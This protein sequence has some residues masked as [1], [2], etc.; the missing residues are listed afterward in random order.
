MNRLLRKRKNA[1]NN[2][3]YGVN[4][5]LK[6]QLQNSTQ[7]AWSTH[8]DEDWKQNEFNVNRLDLELQAAMTTHNF[9]DKLVDIVA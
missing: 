2:Y 6:K 4:I 7:V 5:F 3:T 9:E 1:A 8:I